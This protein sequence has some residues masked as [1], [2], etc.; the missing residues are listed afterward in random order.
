[1][2]ITARMDGIHS[3][4]LET[5]GGEDSRNVFKAVFDVMFI[6]VRRSDGKVASQL[7][8]SYSL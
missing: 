2:E 3:F 4:L 8:F 1:M 7:E 5:E 6:D